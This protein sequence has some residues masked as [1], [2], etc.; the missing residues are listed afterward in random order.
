MVFKNRVVHLTPVVPMKLIGL[1]RVYVEVIPVFAHKFDDVFSLLPSPWFTVET[2]NNPFD[3]KSVHIFH[4]YLM[5]A[6]DS[7]LYQ[8]GYDFFLKDHA[9]AQSNCKDDISCNQP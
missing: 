5:L 6:L 7:A 2:L 9:L 3:F 1:R 8:A 4:L